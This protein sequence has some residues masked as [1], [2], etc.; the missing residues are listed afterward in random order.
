MRG[1]IQSNTAFKQ[2]LKMRE[3]SP[4][5]FEPEQVARMQDEE[6][7]QAITKYIGWDKEKSPIIWKRNAERLIKYWGGDPRNLIKNL[8]TYEEALRRMQNKKG[9]KKTRSLDTTDEGFLG[10]QKK[11]VSLFIYFVDWEGLLQPRFVYPGAI[12]YHYCR[13][14]IATGILSVELEEGEKLGYSDKLTDPIRH[15]FLSYIKKTGCD[16]IKLADVLWLFSQIMCGESPAT[17]TKFMP[18]Y[19]RDKPG[20]VLEEDRPQQTLFKNGNI[21]PFERTKWLNQPKIRERIISTCGRCFMREECKYA[22]PARPYYSKGDILLWPH[23]ID[24]SALPEI[25]APRT[26][27]TVPKHPEFEF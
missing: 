6:I 24:W 5:L 1:S 15:V 18:Q 10:Q 22:I 27:E 12:D 2:L 4:E 25:V 26:S 17:T 20:R 7:Q 13:A 16:P 9:G 23:P 3:E 11:V 8:R 21:P 19:Q 14:H